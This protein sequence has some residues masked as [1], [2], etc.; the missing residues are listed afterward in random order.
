MKKKPRHAHARGTSI[1]QAIGSWLADINHAT[2]KAYYEFK[3]RNVPEEDPYSH[4]E[5][6]RLENTETYLY[7]HKKDA[8]LG[9]R[10]TIHNRSPHV[11]R[12]FPQLWRD[13][14]A[15]MER[16]CP[17]GIGHPDPDE[18]NKRHRVHGCDGCCSGQRW[19]FKNE[20]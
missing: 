2:V 12:K 15:I 14:I 16:I 4:L 8:C 17:H 18:I 19:E 10:C 11:M 3:W 13:D 1:A 7:T 20:Y 5:R 6:N 9:E